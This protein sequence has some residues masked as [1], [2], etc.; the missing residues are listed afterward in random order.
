MPDSER[1]GPNDE[2]HESYDCH[3]Y[4]D[5]YVDCAAGRPPAGHTPVAKGGPR[6]GRSSND[7]RHRMLDS[8][9]SLE[10]VCPEYM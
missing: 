7:G 10:V 8:N 6:V 4:V 5:A 1:A 2:S 3:P 9:R